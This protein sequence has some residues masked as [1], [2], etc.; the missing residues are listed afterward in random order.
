MDEFQA[1]LELRPRESSEEELDDDDAGATGPP[2]PAPATAPATAPAP[3]PAPAPAPAPTASETATPS[4]EVIAPLPLD[5]SSGSLVIHDSLDIEVA[6]GLPSGGSEMS[7][8]EDGLSNSLAVVPEG[9]PSGG[10]EMSAPEDGH[11]R[12]TT[13]VSESHVI[14]AVL[15]PED[16]VP[17]ATHAHEE[18]AVEAVHYVNG[19][20]IHDK[21]SRDVPFRAVARPLMASIE[22]ALPRMASLEQ[23][24]A[25]SRAKLKTQMLNL[26]CIHVGSIER[27]KCEKGACICEFVLSEPSAWHSTSF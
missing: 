20:P 19:M 22:E 3:T 13:A 6:E 4:G 25:L 24:L 12:L 5:T 26:S 1:G 23:R 15:A 16:P 10:S 18:V 11:D 17:L 8:P 21:G 7:P 9:L 27:L 14:P 2:A